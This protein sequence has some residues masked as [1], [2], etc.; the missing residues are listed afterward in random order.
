MTSMNSIGAAS[1][2]DDRV[3]S[4]WG[5]VMETYL[6]RKKLN[7]RR[8]ALPEDQAHMIKQWLDPI[9]PGLVAAAD[10]K[11]LYTH[12][13]P[14]LKPHV[15]KLFPRGTYPGVV[16]FKDN[17][18]D[19][20]QLWN[21]RGRPSTTV[22]K[23]EAAALAHLSSKEGGELFE[24][25]RAGHKD[26][27]WLLQNW[28]T[29]DSRTD[30]QHH[31]KFQYANIFFIDKSK[32]PQKK[33]LR[34]IVDARSING[35]VDTS[36]L[37]FALFS[38]E[39]VRGLVASM[40]A[41][42]EW[43]TVHVD[44]RHYY[45]QLPIADDLKEHFIMGVKAGPEGF[46]FYRPRALPMGAAYAPVIAQSCTLAMLLGADSSTMDGRAYK[47]KDAAE[48]G[49][50]LAFL[51]GLK[52]GVLPRCIPLRGGGALFVLLDNIVV[53]TR[54]ASIAAAWKR[55]IQEVLARANITPKYEVTHVALRKPAPSFGLRPNAG[56][57]FEFLGVV[58]AHSACRLNVDAAAA[59][60]G[61]ESWTA[62]KPLDARWTG[63]YRNLQS[64]LGTLLWYHRVFGTAMFADEMQKFRTIY[65]LSAP[66]AHESYDSALPCLD[67]ESCAYLLTMWEA[68]REQSAIDTAW[69]AYPT[70]STAPGTLLGAVDASSKAQLIGMY[71]WSRETGAEYALQA[72]H[73]YTQQT[74]IALAE[75]RAILFFV[76]RAACFI[77]VAAVG[78]IVL[79]SDNLNAVAWIEKRVANRPEAN[80][81]LVEI[82]AALGNRTLDVR[83][84]RTKDNFAD[85]PS[86]EPAPPGVRPAATTLQPGNRSQHADFY[87]STG[88]RYLK[89]FR[90]LDEGEDRYVSTREMLLLAESEAVDPYRV[91]LNQSLRAREEEKREK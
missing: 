72:K 2:Y 62:A 60:P 86:R 71:L 43:H 50:D 15:A 55:R 46:V 61:F 23:M 13:P 10:V 14:F 5:L 21:H 1:A 22:R 6:R 27:G 25:V 19:I 34:V 17:Y 32:D 33:V 28:R 65:S 63:T 73:P 45:H 35:V 11:Q 29:H 66:G 31:S 84:I 80:Q 74:Q 79:A 9:P 53:V 64:V 16:T 78:R 18:E 91:V 40:S 82:F 90:S 7:I 47:L 38:V 89:Y 30:L 52:D 20:Q 48:L 68:R 54:S 24:C 49:L 87:K 36:T 67:A 88:A 42:S 57:M 8:T 76:S 58:W 81:L 69:R 41:H 75:L 44:L 12:A 4:T 51:R 77:D 59:P 39:H 3:H 85:V 70:P 26:Y 37:G 83:Y 56:E